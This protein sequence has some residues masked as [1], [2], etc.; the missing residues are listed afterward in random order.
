MSEEIK[1]ILYCD[2]YND[3]DD[4]KYEKLL[5]YITNLQKENKELQTSVDNC[6][7]ENEKLKIECSQLENIDY[8]EEI[9]REKVLRKI[10]DEI[11][12][13]Y[14]QRNEKAV[15]YIN[16]NIAIYHKQLPLI[17]IDYEEVINILQGGD[18]N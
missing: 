15:E 13:D 17:A 16:K 3:L 2:M 6:K 8:L 7:Q 4:K 12:D 18:E 1:E 9:N 11:K 14:K 5:N 10:N